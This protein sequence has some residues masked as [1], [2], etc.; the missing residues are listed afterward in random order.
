[1]ISSGREGLRRRSSPVVAATRGVGSVLGTNPIAV[2]APAGRWGHFCL[3]MATSTITRGRVEVALRRDEELQAGW[4]IDRDGR[5]T[6]DARAAFDG[7]LLPLGGIEET[8]GYK[9]YGLMLLVDILTG[10]L[11]GSTAAPLIVPLF[12]T[13]SGKSDLGQAFIAIDPDALDE[14][15]TFEAR[16]ETEFDLL[17]HLMRHPARV[18]TR[19]ALLRS[20]WDTDW[21]TDTHLVEVHIGNLRRKLASVTPDTKHIRTVR[22]VGYR[23]E[24]AD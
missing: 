22:G 16:M 3:D 9:G 19:E 8:G 11:G 10:V 15:G 12:S 23:M 2:A 18:W 1:M 21:A 13:H 7:S 14:P 20:V 4:A 17:T 5:P 24:L 6:T